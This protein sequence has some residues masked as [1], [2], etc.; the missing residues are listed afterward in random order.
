LLMLS[1]IEGSGARQKLHATVG[2][3]MATQATTSQ[4]GTDVIPIA[5]ATRHTVAAQATKTSVLAFFEDM[6]QV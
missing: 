1:E 5:S 2:G 6:T 3:T 4:W